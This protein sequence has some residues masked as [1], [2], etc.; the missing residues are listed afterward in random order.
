M[1]KLQ[2]AEIRRGTW[3]MMTPDFIKAT[4]YGSE[5]FPSFLLQLNSSST[6]GVHIHIFVYMVPTNTALNFKTITQNRSHFH[7]LPAGVLLQE[8]ISCKNA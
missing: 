2:A 3:P 5:I 1:N 4:A 8:Q 7:A 6:T